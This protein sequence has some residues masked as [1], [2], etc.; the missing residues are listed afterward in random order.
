MES[1][2]LMLK[3][4]QPCLGLTTWRALGKSIVICTPWIF[5]SVCCVVFVFGFSPRHELSIINPMP[6]SFYL[7][8]LHAVNLHLNSWTRPQFCLTKIINTQLAS[9]DGWHFEH[10]K[11]LNNL[12][13]WTEW[14]ILTRNIATSLGL[15]S[16]PSGRRYS[17]FASSTM[18]TLWMRAF[19]IFICV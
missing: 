2:T 3:G 11:I 17:S 9:S 12:N 8:H 19:Y 13:I 18:G 7:S 5:V 15:S 1:D 10:L 4:R 16:T 6:P 14:P